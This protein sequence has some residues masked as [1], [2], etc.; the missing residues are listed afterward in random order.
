[1]D[2][3]RPTDITAG[4]LQLRAWQPGDE[5][6][7]A[8][9]LDDPDVGR[10]TPHPFPYL[11]SDAAER[12]AGDAA[13]WA[14]G[15]RAELGV[16]DATTGALLGIV[17]LYR[18]TATDAEV[19]WATAAT[20]RGQGVA[21]EAVA[22][23]C[24]WSFGALGLHRLEAQV[25][26]G[27]WG[28]RRVA[29]KAG[30]ILEG[31]RRRAVIP[32]GRGDCWLYGRLPGDPQADT[33][34]LPAYP[35]VTDGVVTLRRWRSADAPDV[36]RACADDQIARWLPVPVPYTAEAGRGYVEDVV[37][38]Q[39][40]DGSAANVAVVD[41][42]TGQL[43]GAIGLTLRGGLG[44]VGYWTAPWARGRGVATRACRLHTGWA[45]EVLGLPRVE[46]LA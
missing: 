44:E 38:A 34:A 21:V 30:F 22:A 23:L 26:A 13:H 18:M 19:G 24:R 42:R 40:A 32:G 20:A 7:M 41:A 5:A 6:E 8:A 10:W 33:A 4:R 37:V 28:S 36:T 14:A 43:L 17:G 2:D 25:A 16:R 27:N 31:T 39:W 46:L 3:M 45:M 35:D 11:L 12:L 15:T 9:L 1:M 29:E